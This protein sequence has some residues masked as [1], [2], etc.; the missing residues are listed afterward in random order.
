MNEIA[1]RHLPAGGPAARAIVF[2]AAV[3]WC[4]CAGC[5][6]RRD[7]CTT[8][9]S[10]EKATKSVA[11][12]GI[13]VRQIRAF[14]AA[15]AK[16]IKSVAFRGILSRSANI[17]LV[18]ICVTPVMVVYGGKE[19]HPDLKSP[20]SH[21]LYCPR[22]SVIEA[23]R[24]S[25]AMAK[26]DLADHAAHGARFGLRC[27]ITQADGA[28]R[29]PAWNSAERFQRIRLCADPTILPAVRFTHPT[30]SADHDHDH[31]YM[32]PD[33]VPGRHSSGRFTTAAPKTGRALFFEHTLMAASSECNTLVQK[34]NTACIMLTRRSAR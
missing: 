28:L 3:L 23:Q 10:F 4:G 19:L 26:P 9:C 16:S 24:A 15:T 7:A 20:A 31:E 32:A 21:W 1:F 13:C 14:N 30:I 33:M 29:E 22:S 11:F 6:G 25:E 17:L 27:S 8:S 2:P 12:R 18:G 34:M 5:M